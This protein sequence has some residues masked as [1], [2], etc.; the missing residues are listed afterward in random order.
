[1]K[2]SYLLFIGLLVLSI[3]GCA[4]FNTYYNAKRYYNKAYHETVRNRTGKPS[5][6]EKTNYEKAIEKSLK[7]IQYYPK[8]KYV[9]DALFIL[10][11]S[12]FYTQEY[13]KARRKFLELKVNYPESKFTLD[14]QLWLARSDLEMEQFFD[15]EQT[16]N[17]LLTQNIS[18]KMTGE[19][20]YYLGK[21]NEKRKN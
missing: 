8:S 14:N 1:M 20:Y 12:Y 6:K 9:D 19:I 18:S 3:F 5:S 11:K 4:Y 13:H 17:N 7:L 10:G 21:L 15:A 16:L 2:R